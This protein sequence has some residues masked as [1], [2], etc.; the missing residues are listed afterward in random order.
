[1]TLRRLHSFYAAM[2]AL[3]ILSGSH[4]VFAFTVT[5]KLDVSGFVRAIAGYHDDRQDEIVGYSDTVSLKEQSLLALQPTYTVS[6]Q[7]SLTGQF[8][9]YSN[10]SRKSG[11]EWLYLSYQP[12]RR[13]QFRAGKM[14]MPLFSYSASVDVGY[15]YPWITPPIQVYNNYLPS[16]FNGASASYSHIGNELTVYL[17]GYLGYF[18]GDLFLAGSRVDVGAEVNDLAGIVIDVRRGNLSLRASYQIGQSDIKVPQVDPLRK[19]LQQAQFN[20]SAESLRFEGENNFYGTALRYDTLNSFYKAEWVKVET[21]FDLAPSLTG[22]YF[23][24]GHIVSDWTFHLTYAA[25]SYSKVKAQQ[26]LRP[27]A[28]NPAHPLF[29]PAQGYFQLFESVPNGSLDTYTL[30][31]RWDI[32]SNTALKAEVTFLNETAPRSGFFG[33]RFSGEVR[34]AL[35]DKKSS[36]LYQ[37]GWEWVF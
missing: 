24:A 10:S 36:T 31:S 8:V 34:G 22:Y 35:D 2:T 7:F 21:Q 5:D 23:T 13:W 37:L 3:F 28:T 17:E 16:T 14:H 18:D 26:E 30:G 33:T 25:S 32:N 6:D 9:G 29:Q 4:S 19:A 1:M 27:L 15:S 12:N 11:T 20:N